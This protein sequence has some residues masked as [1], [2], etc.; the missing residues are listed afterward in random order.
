MNIVIPSNIIDVVLKTMNNCP[1]PP[2]PTCLFY[3]T[4]ILLVSI[5]VEIQ[6]PKATTEDLQGDISMP[7][8]LIVRAVGLLLKILPWTP[9]DVSDAEALLERGAKDA[10]LPPKYAQEVVES[11]EKLCDSVK[12]NDVQFHWV[13]R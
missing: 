11:I 12:E 1:I 8:P 9:W 13:G 4:A 7:L 3:A 10:G 6:L 2:F 5:F